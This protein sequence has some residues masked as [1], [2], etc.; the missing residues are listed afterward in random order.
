MQVQVRVPPVLRDLVDGAAVI[1][2]EPDESGTVSDVVDLLAIAHPTL[3][4]RIRD[5]RGVVRTHVN[6]FVDDENIRDLSGLDT[7][8]RPGADVSI[9]AAISGG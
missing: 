2:V 1:T 4:R 5:E 6:V 8:L 7:G 9:V 3:A